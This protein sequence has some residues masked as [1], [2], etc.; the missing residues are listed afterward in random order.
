MEILYNGTWGSVCD[1]FW[2]LSEARVVCRMLG[3]QDAIRG[4]GRW[5]WLTMLYTHQMNSFLLLLLFS[6]MHSSHFGKS[7]GPIYL[8]RVRC[9]GT[10]RELSE[11]QNLG[12]G[13]QHC[14]SNH[15]R[16]AGVSCS[17]E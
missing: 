5:V 3:F 10:E 8:D 2:G 14:P 7:R 16:D 17:S 11:C 13:V 4:W 1:N 9:A 15:G 12:F 6:H